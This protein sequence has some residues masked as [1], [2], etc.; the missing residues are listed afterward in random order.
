[1]GTLDEGGDNTGGG[2]P[3]ETEEPVEVKNVISEEGGVGRIELE[4]GVKY[5]V[6]GVGVSVGGM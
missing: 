6:G 1:V 3:E 5:F 4:G 2:V